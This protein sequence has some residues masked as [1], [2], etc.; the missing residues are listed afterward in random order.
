MKCKECGGFM[1]DNGCGVSSISG[2]IYE[3]QS[4]SRT[5]YICAL[6]GKAETLEYKSHTKIVY[7]LQGGRVFA[8][9]LPVN[10]GGN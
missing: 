3:Q 9:H 4:Y 1:Y 2:G 7:H 5:T 10:P 6:C 8:E